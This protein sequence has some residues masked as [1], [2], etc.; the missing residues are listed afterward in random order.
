MESQSTGRISIFNANLL[1][2][3]A[4]V[5]FVIVGS[6][7]QA[8]D[9]N[10]GI[11]I[12]EFLLIALPTIIFVKAKGA[13][14]RRELRFNRLGI[15]DVALVAITFISGYYVAVFIN[16]LGQIV[17]SLMGELITPQI[18]FAENAGDYLVLLFV[19]AV[20]AG[21][22]EEIL[23]RG[24]IMRGYQSLGMWPSIVVSAV[25]F[26]ILHLN[27]QN[28]LAPLFLGLLL[29]FVVYKTNSIFAGML[30]H[31]INNAISVTWGY[32]IMSLPFY[33][34]ISPEAMQEGLLTSSLI[35]VAFL[36]GI[37]SLFAGAIMIFCLKAIYDRHPVVEA[38]ASDV[39]FIDTLK[40]IRTSWP[41][42]VSIL[43]F[44]GMVVVEVFLIVRGKPP[45]NF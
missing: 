7:V 14:V 42:F 20:S 12:T 11:L 39:S 28:T 37:I 41:L 36:F 40:N 8:W 5:L 13:S 38:K 30:G 34:N 17:L 21:I 15:V 29:G 2:M 33:N 35:S 27:V 22:C 16:V 24:F 32:I 25:L 3:I 10:Y 43:I 26:A 45:I 4:M 23:C 31:F 9:F 6:F 1:Y 44:I 18:P 19:I